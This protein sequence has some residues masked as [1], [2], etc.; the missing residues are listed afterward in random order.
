MDFPITS[1]E[2]DQV[3]IDQKKSY[4]YKMNGLDIEHLSN[5]GVES[6]FDGVKNSLNNLKNNDEGFSKLMLSK[7]SNHFYKIYSLGGNTFVS[8]DDETFT[9]NSQK[10]EIDLDPVFSVFSDSD[11]WGSIEFEKDHFVLNGTYW[12]FI[13]LYGVPSKLNFMQLSEVG[14]FFLTFRKYP[15]EEAKK[16]SGRVRNVNQITSDQAYTRNIASENAFRE[17]EEVLENL[18]QGDENLFDFCLWYI[19]RENH[20]EDLDSETK[21][22]TSTLARLDARGLVETVGLSTILESFVPGTAPDFKRSHHATS[23]YLACMIPFNTNAVHKGGIEFSSLGGSP[24]HIN[25]FNP[26]AALNFNGLITG[27]SG[28]GKSVI[29][30]KLLLDSLD[31][32]IKGL[33]LDKGQSFK[34]LTLYT[35]GNIFSEKF[36]PLQFKN[37]HY[38]KAFLMSLIPENEFSIKD[39]GKMFSLIKEYLIRFDAPTFSG[40]ISYLSECFDGIEHYFN[41]LQDFITDSE[42]RITDITYVD[43]ALY[44]KQIIG[45]LII[46]LI[47]YF[48]NINGKKIFLFDE[49]WEYLERNSD[50]IEECFRTFRKHNASAIAI[51]QDV[52]DFLSS[53]SKVG[54]VIYNNTNHKFFF[55]Q[56]TTSTPLIS[57]EDAARIHSLKSIH[58]SHSEFFYKD[59]SIRKTVRFYATPIEYELFTTKKE[60]NLKLDKY[61]EVYGEFLDFKTLMHNWVDFKY[62]HGGMDAQ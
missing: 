34:K 38:L 13:N 44:P 28:S 53:N 14:D 23:S 48:K 29:A 21:R 5:D 40:L 61:I 47:E 27:K 43:T 54:Q 11:F 12:R 51:T 59:D 30:Q 26:Y 15:V 16:I 17:S 20:K 22:I 19:V 57:S 49:C 56:D 6:L 3:Y 1:I 4:F 18:I 37:P 36:N 10:N 55:Y 58:G 24:V 35:G 50:Y 46:Y 8:T 33:I 25:I 45:P 41:E 42:I 32:G 39:Q 7:D 60:D 9:I 62:N 31:S 2:N 52:A